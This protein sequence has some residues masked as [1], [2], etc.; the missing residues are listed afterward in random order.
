V[1]NA[2]DC[3]GYVSAT[4][5]EYALIGLSNGTAFVDITDPGAARI[6][7]Q[8]SGAQSL[9]RDIKVYGDYAYAVSEGGG[10]IQVFDLSEIDAGIVMFRDLLLQGMAD[11]KA[12]RDPRGV[13]R[14]EAANQLHE[15]TATEAILS[16]DEYEAAKTR[17]LAA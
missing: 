14:D 12:G 16:R 17:V 8:M 13:F 5:R 4:G 6:V 11:V 7:T 2:N 9:W 10:G 15:I 1:D 3:W